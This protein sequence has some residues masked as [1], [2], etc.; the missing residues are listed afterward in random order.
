MK[1]L[2]VVETFTYRHEAELAKTAL[3]AAGII[4]M[5][6]A[7]DAGGEVVGLEFTRGVRLLVCPEDEA[8][9]K[10]IL[11]STATRDDSEPG[12]LEA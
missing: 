1:D 10:N 9:A 7:D 4:S 5:I 3:E 2:V 12:D 6:S 11:E 8:S